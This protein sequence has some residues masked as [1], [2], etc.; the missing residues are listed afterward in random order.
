MSI[1]LH[2]SVLDDKFRPMLAGL[3]KDISSIVFPVIATPKFDGIR[4]V[5]RPRKIVEL[6]NDKSMEAIS[7]FLLPIPNGYIQDYLSSFAIAGLDG[8][9]LTWT[10]GKMDK[11]NT[12]MSKV[13]SRAGTPNFSYHVF[14]FINYASYLER[15][16]LLEDVAKSFPSDRIQLVEPKVIESMEQMTAF[17]EQCINDGF[18]GVI[19]RSIDS[20]YKFGRSTPKQGWMM[21]LKRFRDAEATVIGYEELMRNGNEQEMN[22]LGLA[23]RSSHKANLIPGNTLGALKCCGHNGQEF[24]IGSGFDD[25]TRQEIWDN[26]DKYLMM[27][28]KYKY[29]PHGEKDKPRCPIFLG[30]RHELDFDAE[31]LE[32]GNEGI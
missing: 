26:Q 13:M 28:A 21:K 4:C 6:F 11:Y 29:Q 20:P 7:R 8:E 2:S 15:L 5:T 10:D 19:Y 14:D 31:P 27:K 18:E 22:A 9:L 25:A 30:F 17:E 3:C 12:V 32:T 16:K 24:S 1:V 23:E